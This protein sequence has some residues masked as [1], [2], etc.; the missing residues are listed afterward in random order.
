MF[1][2]HRKGFRGVRAGLC[3]QPGFEQEI[4]GLMAACPPP[5]S[6]F[7]NYDINC[8]SRRRSKSSKT[9]SLRHPWGTPW[10][11]LKKFS[12]VSP[13][14]WPAI[15]SLCISEDLYFI[16]CLNIFIFCFQFSI[17]FHD[18]LQYATNI[19]QDLK[20]TPFFPVK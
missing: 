14:V 5:P 20:T 2:E 3:Y 16:N 4:A 15:T 1:F 18:F 10:V 9:F 8:S 17:V 19:M 11:P 6:L 13:A 12:L 7:L